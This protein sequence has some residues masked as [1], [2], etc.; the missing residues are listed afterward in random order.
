VGGHVNQ[1]VSVLDLA[2]GVYHRK[3]YNRIM[4]PI[5]FIKNS[6]LYKL[7]ILHNIIFC[8]PPVH[9]CPRY[10]QDKVIF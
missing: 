4:N 7:D 6:Q 9:G 10:Q 2:N 5:I 3:P 1:G 8:A